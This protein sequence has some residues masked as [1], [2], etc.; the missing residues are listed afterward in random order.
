[1]G[2][3]VGECEDSVHTTTTTYAVCAGLCSSNSLRKLCLMYCTV[4][5]CGLRL[6]ASRACSSF[7]DKPAPLSSTVGPWAY[8]VLDQITKSHSKRAYL[9]LQGFHQRQ[10]K[11]KDNRSAGDTAAWTVSMCNMYTRPDPCRLDSMLWLC[12]VFFGRECL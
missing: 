6:D 9:L 4:V 3:C 7:K 2:S 8:V 11:T 10:A 1:M 12:N 5:S